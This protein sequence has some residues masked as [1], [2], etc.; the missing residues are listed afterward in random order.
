ML[1]IYFGDNPFRQLPA[2][3][4]GKVAEALPLP[5]NDNLTIPLTVGLVS[6]L[7]L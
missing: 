2:A 7:M 5:F 4:L 6:Y 3:L 1:A